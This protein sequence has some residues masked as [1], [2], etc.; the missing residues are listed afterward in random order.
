MV[1]FD[2]RE[3]LNFNVSE[4][5][6]SII[7]ANDMENCYCCQI[8]FNCETIIELPSSNHVRIIYLFV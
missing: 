3:F 7:N 6:I 1:R 8:S 5:R 2:Y 4:K